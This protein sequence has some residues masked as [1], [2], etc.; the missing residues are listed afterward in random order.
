MPV[1]PSSSPPSTI[2]WLQAKQAE[3]A[4]ARAAIKAEK[5][6]EGV[7][8]DG[9]EDDSDPSKFYESRCVG[10]VGRK[11]KWGV[12]PYGALCISYEYFLLSIAITQSA[13]IPGFVI[14]S[15]LPPTSPS[16]RQHPPPPV[17]LPLSHHRVAAIQA[18]KARGENPYPHKF[19]VSISIPDYITKYAD[20]APGEQRKEESEALTGAPP[21]V[22][23]W[24]LCVCVADCVYVCVCVCV[25]VCVVVGGGGGGG[26]GIN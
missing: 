12:S 3:E 14:A 8:L 11:K 2:P 23:F 6:D 18:A 5:G 7:A 17:A 10:L 15:P 22:F 24:G 26:R 4:A 25:C 20:V 9:D 19:H 13:C 21:C 1:L 16:P